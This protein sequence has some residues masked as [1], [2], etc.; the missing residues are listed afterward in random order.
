[1][2]FL[3][4][5]TLHFIGS[6]LWL[7]NSLDLNPDYKVLG[8]AQE[9]MSYASTR[10]GRFKTAPHWREVWGAQSQSL[11]GSLISGTND[12]G[13]CKSQRKTIWTL[14]LTVSIVFSRLTWLT[15]EFDVGLAIP[16]RTYFS[17]VIYSGLTRCLFHYQGSNYSTADDDDDDVIRLTSQIHQ[18]PFSNAISPWQRD[19]ST[20]PS[21]VSGSYRPIHFKINWLQE[22]WQYREHVRKFP[23]VLIWCDL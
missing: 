21:S 22:L 13:P 16:L 9:K 2:A 6:K 19:V 10:R 23:N 18:Q 5:E 17:S 15:A 7:P 1:V 20:T 4:L 11:T 8:H 12:S 3:A 14:V